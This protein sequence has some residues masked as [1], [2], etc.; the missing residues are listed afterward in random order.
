MRIAKARL[1]RKQVRKQAKRER[2][3][4]AQ[5]KRRREQ[6]ETAAEQRLKLE[7]RQAERRRQAETAMRQ[8]NERRVQQPAIQRTR[9]GEVVCVSLVQR[10]RRDDATPAADVVDSVEYVEANDGLPT[11]SVEIAGVRREIKL[12]SC[13]RYTIA[14]TEWMQHG[15]RIECSNPVDYVE[16][17]GGFLLDVI[18]VWRFRMITVFGEQVTVDACVVDGCTNEFLLGVDFMKARGA[19]MDFSKGEVRYREEERAVVIPFRTYDESGG[20]RVAAVRVVKKTQLTANSV[21]RIEVAVPAKDGEQGIF[22]PT[23]KIGS[24]M[25]AATV[26]TARGG[27]AWVPVINGNS[28]P[29]RLP[30][31]KELGTWV[32][33]EDD[34]TI[35]AMGGGLS[36]P[37]VQRWL[38]DLG[39]GDTPLDNED[40]V[41]IGAEEPKD[42]ALMLKLLRVY[43]KVTTSAGDCPP[44]TI[45]NIQHHIDT[46]DAAPVLLKRRRQAQVEDEVVDSNV[47]KMLGAG[48]IE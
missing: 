15:D 2:V 42:R 21:T 27:R 39:D 29:A 10:R 4:R 36:T 16:G 33:L 46:G 5:A 32:P 26:T 45:L 47:T 23:T 7:A 19:I 31:K 44:A 12:D 30:N 38:N 13:A 14:G 35:L 22:L 3:R 20:A 1:A 48:V 40:E 6:Q 9:D 8:L 25:L 37:R 17:I 41:Q 28:A 11:A 18:G 34:M 43:R 24:V